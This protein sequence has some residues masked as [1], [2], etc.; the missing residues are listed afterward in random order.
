M[1]MN[2]SRRSFLKNTITGIAATGFSSSVLANI[3][4]VPGPPQ[5]GE[6]NIKLRFVVASDGH[7]GEPKTNFAGSHENMV[8]W[9]NKENKKHPLDFAIFN[10]DLVHDRPELLAEVKSKYFDRL[11]FPFY[12]TQGNHDH[13]DE[14]LWTSVFGHSNNHAFDVKDT[15]FILGN[16]S[17]TKGTYVC[18]D[19]NFLKNSLEKYKDKKSV[20]V[21]LHIPAHK[22]VPTQDFYLECP[23]AI[24]L[25]MQYPNIKAVLHGH[26]HSNDD[27]FYTGNKLPHLFDGHYG[28][29]WGTYYMGYRV[30]EVNDDNTVRTYQVNASQSPIISTQLIR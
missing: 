16:T 24:Q 5:S 26:D 3:I 9:L 23:E 14:T 6:R 20:F 13:A 12:A 15:A 22:W 2:N 21:V 30:V 4:T 7:Y 10:G 27:V 11:E 1:S 8:R 19:I 29:S 18:P 25:F 28:G 17:D